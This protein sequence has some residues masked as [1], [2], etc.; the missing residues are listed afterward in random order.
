MCGFSHGLLV[1]LR[2]ASA[3]Q[4]TDIN[5]PC[6]H[7]GL[8]DQD[9]P[10]G[11][12]T[13]DG[14]EQ[15]AR[16]WIASTRRARLAR[17]EVAGGCRGILLRSTAEGLTATLGPSVHDAPEP[18]ARRWHECGEESS[19]PRPLRPQ[20]EQVC[21]SPCASRRYGA[22]ARSPA[23]TAGWC[24]HCA[25][26]RCRPGRDVESIATAVR[27]SGPRSRGTR[28]SRH[29]AENRSVET[30]SGP[31]GWQAKDSAVDGNP[32]RLAT[33]DDQRDT[34]LAQRPR[35]PEARSCAHLVSKS[36]S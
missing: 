6:E 16:I 5:S 17:S 23:T 25:P 31:S 2:G 12:G 30:A 3:T 32:A 35:F 18:A 27:A 28:G 4:W 15:L 33:G 22:V 29:V 8:A 19:A 34:R 11:G 20:R 1:I 7:R 13:C 9:Q 14:S 10:R 21:E 36:A 24:P 26:C